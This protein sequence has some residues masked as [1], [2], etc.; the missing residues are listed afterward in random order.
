M[1]LS[2][3]H[4]LDCTYDHEENIERFGQEFGNTGCD[5]GWMDNLWK[6]N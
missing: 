1:P 4:A 6:F 5:G 3:Q 2:E